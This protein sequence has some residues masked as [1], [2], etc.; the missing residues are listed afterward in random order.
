MP[1]CKKS[2][3]TNLEGN[4]F[5]FGSAINLDVPTFGKFSNSRKIGGNKS[6]KCF[7]YQF[8]AF[9]P[10]FCH[11]YRHVHFL[12]NVVGPCMINEKSSHPVNRQQSSS[13]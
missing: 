6:L 5:D 12:E 8:L 2:Q 10:I 4:L 9:V 7:T 1:L 3:E 11:R 13:E